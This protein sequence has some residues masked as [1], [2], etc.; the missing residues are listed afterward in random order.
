MPASAGAAALA[1]FTPSRDA[2]IV[3]KLR[4]A[5]ALILGKTNMT[6]FADYVSDVMP[7]GFSSAGGVVANPHGIAYD[8]GQGSSVGSAAAVAASFAVFAVGT[9]TQ[10]SIQTPA[11]YTSV[12][13]YKPTVGLVGRSGIIPLVPSQDTPGPLCRSVADAISV[14][15]AIAGP[16]GHDLVSMLPNV[17]TSYDS[18]NRGVAGVRIGVP[19]RCQADRPDFGRVMGNFEH[20]LSRPIGCRCGDRRS[21][22]FAL[23]R[24]TAGRTFECFPLRVQK[25]SERISGREWFSLRAAFS[26]RHHRLECGASGAHSLRAIAAAGGQRDFAGRAVSS[27]PAARPYSQWDG[28]HRSGADSQTTRTC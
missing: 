22:R 23:G 16:D 7:S 8:R 20:V 19:R 18:M 28:R 3:R 4:A 10:N 26:R 15:E 24:A 21:L 9:E 27:R 12:V 6:E 1:K 13:G 25:C 11:C 5:G 17:T 14:I 2:L